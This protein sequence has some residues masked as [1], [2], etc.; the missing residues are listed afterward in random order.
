[1]TFITGS[2]RN[3]QTALW[4]LH[5]GGSFCVLESTDCFS[6]AH[7]TSAKFIFASLLGRWWFGY[8]C[9][10]LWFNMG[11]NTCINGVLLGEN[12]NKSE[13]FCWQNG[14]LF[15]FLHTINIKWLCV[16]MSG[17]MQSIWKW[18]VHVRELGHVYC[19]Q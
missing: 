4:L 15:T 1:M 5:D 3:T 6:T 7:A 19:L 10:H 13:M 2:N 14:C 16:H 9:N 12:I 8:T 18:I 17:D 11:N